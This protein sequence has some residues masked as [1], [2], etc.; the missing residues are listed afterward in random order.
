MVQCTGTFGNE[1]YNCALCCHKLITL[2]LVNDGNLIS[3]INICFGFKKLKLCKT[4]AYSL[5]IEQHENMVLIKQFFWKEIILTKKL[6]TFTY[7]GCVSRENV[8]ANN[9]DHNHIFLSCFTGPP[10]CLC[11][12]SCFGLACIM[13]PSVSAGYKHLAL[14]KY[15]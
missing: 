2:N 12:V 14:L 10:S 9:Y 8:Y 4:L 6:I 3:S 11:S 5:N 15:Q 13:A 1:Y 7:H